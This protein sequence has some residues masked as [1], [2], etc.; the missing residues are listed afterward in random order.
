MNLAFSKFRI[1]Y[2]EH[3][4]LQRFLEAKTRALHFEQTTHQATK[5]KLEE[6]KVLSFLLSFMIV[7]YCYLVTSN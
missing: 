3:G 5:K 2:C 1:N 7:C 6:F 4:D